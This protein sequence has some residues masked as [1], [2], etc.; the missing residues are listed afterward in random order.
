MSDRMLRVNSILRQVLAEEMEK[1]SDTRLEM[2]S[3]TG[4]DTAPNLRT[5]M[6]YIDVLGAENHEPALA[7]LRGASNRLQAA[8][9]REVRIKYTPTL[10]F[11]IDPGVVGGER[12]EAILRELAQ[13]P[14]G[15]DE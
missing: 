11:A 13:T 6:V 9:G 7:A 5:A 10:E 15:E 12:I 4:V 3:V 1:L 2:V 8:I 14:E